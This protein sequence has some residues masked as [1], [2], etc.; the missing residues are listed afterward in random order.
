MKHSNVSLFVPHLGC[1]HRCVFCDQRMISGETQPITREA[2]V[3]ACETAM[4]TPHSREHS[5]IA[6]FG[7]SFTAVDRGVQEMCLSAAAP[8]LKT[9]F[10]GIRISTRPD[11]I[12]EAE[13]RFLKDRGVT[14][15]ELGAQ[16]MD[17]KVL[18][19]N[20]RGHTPED[21]VRASE[22]IR[23]FGFSVGLQMMTG[24]YG[25]TDETDLATAKAFIRLAPDTVRIYPTVVLEGTALDALYRAGDYTPPTL[26]QSVRSCAKLIKLF[27]EHGIRVIRVGLHSGGDVEKH[28]VAGPYHPAFRELCESEIYRIAI[29]NLLRGNP[30]GSYTVSVAPGELSKATGQKRS[31]PLHFTAAGYRIRIKEDAAAAIY[32]P[33]LRKDTECT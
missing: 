12:D 24:L 11:A 3:A 33:L 23:D 31:N 18:M 16:S 29:E 25:S 13:L 7:G 19:K 2:I 15:I 4:R 21:T 17:A 30:P 32:A 8:Y 28:L 20:E 1:P 14:A 27:Y 26:E 6:F 10:S 9:G 22:M 5:E